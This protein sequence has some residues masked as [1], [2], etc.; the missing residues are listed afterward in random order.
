MT[1]AAPVSPSASASADEV[2]GLVARLAEKLVA[3]GYEGTLG[4]EDCLRSVA[5]AYGYRA[6][7]TVLAESA[8]IVIDGK[9]RVVAHAP[10]IPQLDQVSAF[11][12]WLADV[13]AGRVPLSVARRRLERIAAMPPPYPPWARVLGVVLFSVGFGVSIQPTWQEV[14][15]T[16]VLGLVVGLIQVGGQVLR[17]PPWLAPL[18]A[19][20]VVSLAVLTAAKYGWVQGGTVELMIPVLFVFIPGDAITMAMV[21]LSVGRITAGSARLMQSLA[22]LATLAFG[23]VL[24][25]AVLHL[26][27]HEIFDTPVAP[28]LGPWAGWFG[29]TVFTVGLLL[30]FGMRVADL[31][32]SLA[33]VLGTYGVQM[34]ATRLLGNVG[35]TFVAASLM[36]VACLLLDRRQDVPPAFVLYLAPFFLLTPG[37]HGLRG[38]DVMLG[39][40]VAGASDLAGMFTLIGAIALGML[41]ASALF[42]KALTAGTTTK[43]ES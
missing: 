18:I 38:L 27:Q 4:V 12:P 1:A 28:T 20:T 6:E 33:M 3:G 15:V 37:A 29:W 24:A 8:V 10:E 40:S 30:V 5:G 43:G 16:A 21:E 35:G 19:S 41:T 32:W 7:V 23:P 31:P 34:V 22:V 17:R 11:K 13:T 9:T 14:R 2:L 25:A 36:A 39:G 42:P 26:R